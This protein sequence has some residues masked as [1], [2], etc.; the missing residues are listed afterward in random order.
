MVD[1]EA[2][3]DMVIMRMIQNLQNLAKQHAKNRKQVKRLEDTILK[4]S[5]KHLDSENIEA[6]SADI[7][8]ALKRFKISPESRKTIQA[9]M[10]TEHGKFHLEHGLSSLLRR[11][12]QHSSN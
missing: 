2:W 12:E 3:G 5:R 4:I 9:A 1:H 11:Y 8:Q 6:F 7:E 10:L